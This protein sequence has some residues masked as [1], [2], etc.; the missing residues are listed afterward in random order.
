VGLAAKS[1][2]SGRIIAVVPNQLGIA[3]PQLPILGALNWDGRSYLIPLSLQALP[4]LLQKCQ[5]FFADRGI[6]QP[7]PLQPLANHIGN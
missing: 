5:M 6:L 2:V 4:R 1:G 7:Q 3:G